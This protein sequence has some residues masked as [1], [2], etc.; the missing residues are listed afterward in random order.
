[1]QAGLGR[2]DGRG[3][4]QEFV[5]HSK[6]AVEM[7]TRLFSTRCHSNL[8]TQAGAGIY[9]C[10]HSGAGR[11][12][13]NKAGVVNGLPDLAD[14]ELR[15]LPGVVIPA[16]AGMDYVNHPACSRQVDSGLRRNDD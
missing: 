3:L 8:F 6:K 11:N 4:S 1:M 12:P 9:P 13:G 14:A 15:G 2:H 7:A 5:G 10:R 16:Q